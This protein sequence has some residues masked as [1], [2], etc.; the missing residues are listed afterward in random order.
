MKR[1]AVVCLF[2]FI[3]LYFSGCSAAPARNGKN[4]L[5]SG[6][7]GQTQ[8]YTAHTIIFNRGK[9]PPVNEK[10][11]R[12]EVSLTGNPSIKSYRFRNHFGNEK[13][14][15]D[16]VVVVAISGNRAGFGVYDTAGAILAEY[17][18]G[19]VIGNALVFKTRTQDGVSNAMWYFGD[20]NIVSVLEAYNSGGVLVYSEVTTYVLR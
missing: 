17:S 4:I 6:R 5:M 11:F 7:A 14:A 2:I 15:G 1:F 13:N 12:S 19:D 3:N 20:T 10:T 8:T 9:F 18:K 16:T